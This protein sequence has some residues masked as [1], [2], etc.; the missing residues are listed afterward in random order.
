MF[1]LFYNPVWLCVLSLLFK[2]T[3]KYKEIMK[4]IAD[5]YCNRIENTPNRTGMAYTANNN[6]YVGYR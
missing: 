2:Y 3:R 1:Y 4:N 6:Q 5:G